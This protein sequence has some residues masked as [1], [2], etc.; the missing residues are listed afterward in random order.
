MANNREFQLVPE[1]VWIAL[2]RWYKGSSPALP[3]KVML[4]PDTKKLTIELNPPVVTVYKHQQSTSQPT[5]TT[6]TSIGL[7]TFSNMGAS[8]M[9]GFNPYVVLSEFELVQLLSIN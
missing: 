1:S 8:T 3:R 6:A 7:N 4:D 9:A 2:T 5:V